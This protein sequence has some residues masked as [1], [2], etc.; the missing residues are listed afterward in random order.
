MG[1]CQDSVNHAFHITWLDSVNTDEYARVVPTYTGG[2]ITGFTIPT[3]YQDYNDGV[4]SPGSR[5]LSEVVDSASAHRLM[6]VGTGSAGGSTGLYKLAV[7]TPAGGV[8]PG[9]F[10]AWASASDHT[11]TT[12]DDQLL[13]NNYATGD[14]QATF[15]TTLSSNLAGGAASPVVVLAGFPVDKKLLMWLVHP[16]ASSNFTIGAP[17]MVSTAFGGGTGVR[18]DASLSLVSAPNGHTLFVY[19]DDTSSPQPGLHVTDVDPTGA[20]S[21]LPQPTTNTAARHA[22]IA[23]DSMSRPAIL[24]A[25]G[26]GAI[27]ATLYWPPTSSWLPLAPVATE[28]TPAS[29]WSITNLWQPGGADTFGYYRDSGAATSTTFSQIRWQ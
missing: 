23:T 12:G 3:I 15:M 6:F 9:T 20:V 29:A 16:A 28:S 24:Y 25:D 19:G 2:D 1:V 5:D 8:A 10:S 27:V 4:D 21:E 14:R 11:I 17:V 18:A 7:T 26:A 13:P 22:V